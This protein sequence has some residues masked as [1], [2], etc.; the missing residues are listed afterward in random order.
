MVICGDRSAGDYRRD[1]HNGSGTQIANTRRRK[2][3]SRRDQNV[4]TR[5][6]GGYTK[7]KPLF[8]FKVEDGP[9]VLIISQSVYRYDHRRERYLLECFAIQASVLAADIRAQMRAES[10]DPDRHR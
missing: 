8:Q 5:Q 6:A 3:T 1:A 4:G 10:P 9:V 7:H 2:A